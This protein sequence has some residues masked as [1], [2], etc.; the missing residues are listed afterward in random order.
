VIY[1][2][3]ENH[4]FD[5]IAGYWDFHP[6]IDNL[7]GVTYCNEY[8]N[9]NWTVW[10]EPLEICAAPYETEVPLKD[11]DHNFAGVTYEIFRKWNVTKD[12]V[13]NMAG[14]VERQSEK[15]SST[16]G[17]TSFVIQAYNQK[18]TSLLAEL[19][20]NFAFF[21]SYVSLK[22]RSASVH[23]IDNFIVR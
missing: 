13:P 7:R 1:L 10:G 15:Y 5:D 3:L 20:Q 8:T 18:K 4:S 6:D 2:T 21:D 22:H 19:G 16:P 9:P 17:D 14:F 12:D 23:T 11:P